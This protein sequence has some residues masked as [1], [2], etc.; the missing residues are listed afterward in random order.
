MCELG[1]QDLMRKSSGTCHLSNSRL[2][3]NAPNP[4]E[5]P[6]C[7]ETNYSMSGFLLFFRLPGLAS[8]AVSRVC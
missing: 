4:Y 1:K 6:G 7:Q 2:H 3:G 5:A 8:S